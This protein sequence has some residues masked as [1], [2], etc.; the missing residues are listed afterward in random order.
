[1]RFLISGATG[2]IGKNV[3]RALHE[4]GHTVIGLGRH[5]I[6][7]EPYSTIQLDLTKDKELEIGN[8]DVCIHM[9]ALTR[10]NDKR[11]L[12]RTNVTGTETMLRI[13]HKA[14]AKRFVYISTGGVYGFSNDPLTENMNPSPP[15][16]YSTTKC[17]GEMLA[18]QYSDQFEVTILRY[19]FPYGPETNKNDMINR[20]I[21]NIRHDH[22]ITLN[23]NSQPI[24]NPIYITDLVEATTSTSTSNQKTNV[25][26]FNVAGS[27]QVNILQLGLTIAD[28]TK[29]ELRRIQ[30]KNKC[31]NMIGSI[32]KITSVLKFKPKISLKEG[33]R[34]TMQW[35]R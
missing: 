29:K 13:S 27:E 24:I 14:K 23:K 19:F 9:A 11:M 28:F 16:S 8:I 18:K 5:I 31:K 34:R 2:G 25:E 21:D 30:T 7:N 26:I 15:N 6:G 33:I 12:A 3:A 35:K 20:L 1:M 4:Q 17:I 10:S 32:D 22:S